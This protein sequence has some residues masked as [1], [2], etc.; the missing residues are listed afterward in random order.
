MKGKR[1]RFYI[2]YVLMPIFTFQVMHLPLFV[3]YCYQFVQDLQHAVHGKLLKPDYIEQV[4]TTLR[5]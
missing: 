5:R 4:R 1:K 2:Q 3:D